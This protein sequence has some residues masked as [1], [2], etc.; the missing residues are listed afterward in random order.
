MMRERQA[1]AMVRGNGGSGG[2][3]SF[4]GIGG[5]VGEMVKS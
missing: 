4:M 1:G 5:G 3:L 2:S